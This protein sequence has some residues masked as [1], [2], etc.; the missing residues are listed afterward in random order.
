MLKCGTR[1]QKEESRGIKTG[2]RI[3]GPHP[4]KSGFGYGKEIRFIS[5]WN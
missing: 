1:L 4:F 5:A 2:T 3:F